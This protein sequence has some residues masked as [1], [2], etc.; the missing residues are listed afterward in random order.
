MGTQEYG[1]DIT[2][3]MP[4]YM[5]RPHNTHGM[6]Y[7]FQGWISAKD[8]LSGKSD[9]TPITE[10]IV[11]GD[12]TYYAFYEE[13]DCATKHSRKDYFYFPGDGKTICLKDKYRT[14]IKEPVT[15]PL[16]NGDI[17]LTTVA[18]FG[19]RGK[20][21]VIGKNQIP[22]IYFENSGAGGNYKT[23]Q[24]NAF[25]AAPG[26][27]GSFVDMNNCQMLLSEIYL[28]NTITTIG[29]AAFTGCRYLETVQLPDT[30][31]SGV[32]VTKIDTNAFSYTGKIQIIEGALSKLNTIGVAAFYNA[33]NGVYL[34][35][36]PENLKEIKGWA[37]AHC[38]NV[39]PGVFS[40]VTNIGQHAFDTS[41][42]YEVI[43]IVLPTDLSDF[44][45][46]CFANYSIGRINTI[47]YV[48][49]NYVD[50][51]TL[52]RLGITASNPVTIEQVIEG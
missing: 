26:G 31:Q 15:L 7:E 42:S 19:F 22:A 6:R 52:T 28:P 37:F 47:T 46:D 10:F 48:G 14:V 9:V 32:G 29:E 18:D 41:N 24:D 51:D 50:P 25:C 30:T 5:Y 33:G 21:D 12:T 35:S 20:E 34:A 17:I 8:Y 40:K 45:D 3:E 49:G 2:E 43:N 36:I 27:D 16:K 1:A 4:F 13:Q 38:G 39:K 23:I 44:S 11:E